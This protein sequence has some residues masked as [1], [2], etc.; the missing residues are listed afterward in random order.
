MNELKDYQS[1]LA[2]KAE[3]VENIQ[4][5]NR[6]VAVNMQQSGIDGVDEKY[7]IVTVNAARARKGR[8]AKTEIESRQAQDEQVSADVV[9]LRELCNEYDLIRV[10]LGAR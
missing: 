3:R 6:K 4:E 8:F 7:C 1:V 5:I 2:E 9:A 10:E